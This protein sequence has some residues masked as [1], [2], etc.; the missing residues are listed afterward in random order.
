MTAKKLDQGVSD[1]EGRI[2]NLGY[3]LDAIR[4]SMANGL[5]TGN[6]LEDLFGMTANT[7]SLDY[8]GRKL[9]E[10]RKTASETKDFDALKKGLDDLSKEAESGG[11]MTET[12]RKQ[13]DATQ[14]LASLGIQLNISITGQ[15][16]LKNVQE[17]LKYWQG[18]YTESSTPMVE[19]DWRERRDATTSSMLKKFDNDFQKTATAKLQQAR[20]DI[21]E[22]KDQIKA[23]S[24][25][26]ADDSQKSEATAKLNALI[27]DRQ[28]T[29]DNANKAGERS[30]IAAAKAE[31]GYAAA[32]AETT[33]Q[34]AGYQ[35]QLSFDKSESLGRAKAKIE[36]E[37]AQAVEKTNKTIKDQ[38]AEK[39]ITASEGDTLRQL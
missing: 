37:Y 32:V 8:Y 9:V 10:L 17:R 2:N 26:Y 13:I 34:I 4:Q 38:V 19:T 7:S 21:K 30:A 22:Y 27:K 36:A 18:I 20:D 5:P 35:Q 16:E 23:I 25:L 12:L 33:A 11:R 14:K 15:E 24:S 28:A 6:W 39:K 1:A 31:N 3:S 29:I